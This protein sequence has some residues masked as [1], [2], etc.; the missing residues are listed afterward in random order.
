MEEVARDL[1]A[2]L[3][4]VLHQYREH[5]LAEVAG[6]GLATSVGQAEGDHIVLGQ[7]D[8]VGKNL[9]GH[10]DFLGA[11]RDSDGQAGQLV[12]GGGQFDVVGPESFVVGV[13]DGCVFLEGNRDIF[14]ERLHPGNAGVEIDVLRCGFEIQSYRVSLDY[15]GPVAVGD[16]HNRAD[17]LFRVVCNGFILQ[18]GIEG[19]RQES[20]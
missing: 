7:V 1:I 19:E 4:A 18:A 20:E 9:Y 5:D 6:D 11:G 13:N 2:G 17:C 10:F 14:V 15:R 8:F 12:G 3:V 16:E